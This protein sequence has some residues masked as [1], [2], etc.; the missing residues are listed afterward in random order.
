MAFGLAG[1]PIWMVLG[2]SLH[3][4]SHTWKRNMTTWKTP[5]LYKLLG[6]LTSTAA[7]PLERHGLKRTPNLPNPPQNLPTGFLQGSSLGFAKRAW[8]SLVCQGS[9]WFRFSYIKVHQLGFCQEVPVTFLFS[10]PFC[11]FLF[12]SKELPW[13]GFSGAAMQ[14]SA[15]WSDELGLK[16]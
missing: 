14:R 4:Q 11:C 12:P 1:H 13:P 7:W 8:F 6:C 3:F 10:R 5:S 15:S 9:S 2:I 16:G